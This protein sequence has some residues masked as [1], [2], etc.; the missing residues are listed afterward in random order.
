M[1][2]A[3]AEGV[4]KKIRNGIGVSAVVEIILGALILFWHNA[5]TLIVD[6][7]GLGFL[8]IGLYYLIISFGS[9]YKDTGWARVGHLLLA[10]LYI[11]VGVSQFVALYHSKGFAIA[12]DFWVI[13]L[14]VGITWIT[15]GFMGFGSLGYY[16]S[17]SKG[18]NVFASMISVIAGFSLIFS[19]L[20]GAAFLFVFS[21]VLLLIVGIANLFRFF[22]W[23]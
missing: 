3:I 13:G 23:K 17:T 21:G 9:D 5:P 20:A 22:F 12:T 19:P 7:I 1:I 11:G 2:S 8:L 15:E 4:S 16:N 14:L 6:I 10:A 18:W